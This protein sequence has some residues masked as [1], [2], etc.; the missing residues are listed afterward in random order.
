MTKAKITTLTCGCRTS[1]KIRL[2]G[3]PIRRLC[4]RHFKILGNWLDSQQ[5]QEV[6]AR[7][8]GTDC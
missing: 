6:R 7:G 4:A 8:S 3:T 5:L 1:S 2:D